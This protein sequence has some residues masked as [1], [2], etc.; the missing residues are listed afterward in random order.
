MLVMLN[1]VKSAV[2]Y[3]LVGLAATAIF[4]TFLFGPIVLSY[5]RGDWYT[6]LLCPFTIYAA[7]K[8]SSDLKDS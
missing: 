5:V 6:L 1:E 4:G 7:A 8:L 2:F 3:F